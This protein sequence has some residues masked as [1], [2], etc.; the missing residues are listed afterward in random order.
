MQRRMRRFVAGLVGVVLL[1]ITT[2]CATTETV[3]PDAKL[4][5]ERYRAGYE[6]GFQEGYRK[7]VNK[8]KE[9]CF[10]E[11][12]RALR[13]DAEVVR[14]MALW[15]R[16]VRDGLLVPPEVAIIEETPGVSPDGRSFSPPRYTLVVTA[17]ARFKA[18]TWE[19]FLEGRGGTLYVLGFYN[20][21]EEAVK[22]KLEQMEKAPLADHFYVVPVKGARY[23]YALIVWSRSGRDYRRE[24]GT[25]LVAS[26]PARY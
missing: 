15:R 16:M 6:A 10:E 5:K 8:G 4:L 18:G 7:G 17:P 1:G 13:N 2:G 14:N 12:K 23:R 21:Y 9:M 26:G 24:G 25:P 11:V 20:D 22:A 19:D 3:S